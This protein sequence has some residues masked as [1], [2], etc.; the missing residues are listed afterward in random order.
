VE[1]KKDHPPSLEGVTN[2]D[3]NGKGEEVM[4][5]AGMTKLTN[6][7]TTTTTM[8]QQYFNRKMFG[9]LRVN[10]VGKTDPVITI[11]VEH[12]EYALS[13]QYSNA[14]SNIPMPRHVQVMTKPR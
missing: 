14:T 6:T 12:V 4:G 9:D 10:N 1:K 8:R 7:M 11:Q 2:H 13:Q 3:N 5:G